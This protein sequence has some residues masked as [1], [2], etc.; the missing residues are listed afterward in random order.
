MIQRQKVRY[1]KEKNILYKILKNIKM[2]K[3][4]KI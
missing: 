2:K 1:K 3:F 4:N